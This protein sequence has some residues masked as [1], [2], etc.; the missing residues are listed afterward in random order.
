MDSTK[1]IKGDLIGT[2]IFRRKRDEDRKKRYEE[3]R[4]RKRELKEKEIRDE[5]R[6]NKE[7]LKE[8]KSSKESEKQPKEKEGDEKKKPDRKKREDLTPEEKEQKIRDKREAEKLRRKEREEREKERFRQKEEK[9]R[10]IRA[11]RMEKLKQDLE[12]KNED[13]SSEDSLGKLKQGDGGGS[14]KANVDVPSH[15]GKKDATPP[16][17]VETIEDSATP[18]GA[19]KSKR[20]SDRRKEERLKKEREKQE[21]LKKKVESTTEVEENPITEKS[22]APSAT[23][24]NKD[25]SPD[26]KTKGAVEVDTTVITLDEKDDEDIVAVVKKEV[27]D[28]EK[29]FCLKDLC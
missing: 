12:K 11:E 15:E 25:A 5:E 9:A 17:P 18:G 8:E 1:S 3:E 14:E 27:V 28:Q 16:T 20:Y 29:V 4:Q 10:K 24:K 7:R 22:L 6:R 2:Y 13:Q 19:T 23:N 21:R 26:A